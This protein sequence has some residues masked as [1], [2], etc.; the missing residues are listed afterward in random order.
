MEKWDG[1]NVY[2][3]NENKQGIVLFKMLIG[4]V[5]NTL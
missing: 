4:A 5:K 2:V 3:P 1:T